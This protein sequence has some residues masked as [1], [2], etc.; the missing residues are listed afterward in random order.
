L[1]PAE[2]GKVYWNGKAVDDPAAFFVPPRCAYVPQ[3]P[4]L[5]SETL[6][7]NILM[8]QPEEQADL[9]ACLYSAVM[10]KDVGELENGLD[11]IVGPRGVKLSGGQIQR[12]AAARMFICNSSLLVFD[13]LSSALDIETERLMW[14]RLFANRAFTCL[15]VSHRPSVLRRADHILVLKDGKVESEGTWDRLLEH[16]DEFRSIWSTDSLQAEGNELPKAN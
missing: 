11:T 12:A 10:E 7:D 8:G 15:V 16:S 4:H 14:E 3:V 6:K 5:Y 2:E 9:P 13:D 1:L